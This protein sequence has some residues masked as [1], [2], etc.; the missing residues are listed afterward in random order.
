M[1]LAEVKTQQHLAS[2]GNYRYSAIYSL[3]A[4]PSA[5]T[6]MVT[7]TFSDAVTNGIIAGAANF[8]NVDQTTPL[9]TPVGAEGTGTNSHPSV[10]LTG[11]NGNE[12]VFDNVF[13]GASDASQ[14]IT[15]NSGPSA[16]WN[17]SGV[18][19]TNFNTI[20][21]ASNRQAT[22]ASATMS[23]ANTGFSSTTT[24]WAI[25]AVPIKPAT[26][27]PSHTVTFD[28]N[29][30]TGSIN[31][32]V[33]NAPTTLTPNTFS[34]NGF[35]FSGWGINAG[36]P[37]VYSDN[38][39]YDFSADITL[40][41]QWTANTYMVTFDAN[42]GGTPSP[43]SKQV[44][45]NSVYGT[46]ATSSRS[47]Y[48]LAG[49]FTA[50]S[51][52]T[53]VTAASIVSNASNHTLYAQWTANTYT[54]TFDANGGG[55]PSPASKQVTFGAAYGTLATS[56][57]SG[58]TL[59]GWFTAASGGTEV[60]A[61]SIVSNASDHSLF[62]HWTAAPTPVVTSAAIPSNAAPSIGDTITVPININISGA[63]LGSYTG[64]LDWDPAILSYQSYSDAPPTG[65]TGNV[66]SSNSATGHIAF[67][68]ANA[69]GTT[70]N[71]LV[72]TV[73]FSVVGSG[74]SAL[75]LNYSAMAAASTFESLLPD[76]TI[77]DGQVVVAA[78]ASHTVTF[79]A[80]GGTGTMRLRRPMDPLP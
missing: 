68:G 66:N 14:A 18:G 29:G 56:S 17:I 41:A 57:R 23:W 43:T 74:T 38:A 72:I 32:L 34:R 33:A 19:T 36:G 8:A 16:L 10:G 26:E 30:G 42:G 69:S 52:G 21:A 60:T 28:K 11:L 39:I 7:I 15:P 9:G 3:L 13:I 45:Y 22:G 54:V 47:G 24:H 46:L 73:S 51:G 35:T 44:T 67:N 75:D 62:A 31:P 37:V 59:T 79:N 76:L 2:S 48:T 53:E 58:Y 65:F 78:P 49:W 55:T 64:T 71:T 63:A 5:V 50:A 70:G 61:A 80:N 1:T 20:G 4:P 77:T 25:A 6:G 27:A 12:L 40:Y